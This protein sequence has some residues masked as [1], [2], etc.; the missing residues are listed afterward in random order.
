MSF[1]PIE[2]IG[3]ENARKW[4]P[5]ILSALQKLL[6]GAM[7][8]QS[9]N[10]KPAIVGEDGHTVDLG[11]WYKA[12]AFVNINGKMVSYT[13]TPTVGD[14]DYTTGQVEQMYGNTLTLETKA[15]PGTVVTVAGT[16]GFDTLPA[17]LQAVLSGMASAMQRHADETDII[18]SK[19]IEDVSVSYQRNTTTDTLTQAIQPYLTVINMWSL[20]GKPLGVGGIATPNT[21][22]VVPY[23]IGD[24][25]G[26][27]L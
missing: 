4:L 9:T 14:M 7:V 8:A 22:P 16:Y 12:V 13:F 21:L 20:C 27:E 24:G 19:S 1:I 15:E 10:E 23:W 26:L 18:T 11:A 17:S 25:D 2:N 6:C 5:T 3:G